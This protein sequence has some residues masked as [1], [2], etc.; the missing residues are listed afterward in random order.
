MQRKRQFGAENVVSCLARDAM[1]WNAGLGYSQVE[2]PHQCVA[3]APTAQAVILHIAPVSFARVV[4]HSRGTGT[5]IVCLF[6][7]VL[8]GM[9]VRTR[10]VLVYPS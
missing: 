3:F 5:K 9:S 6:L 10:R 8:L 7:L 2:D 1:F 4:I